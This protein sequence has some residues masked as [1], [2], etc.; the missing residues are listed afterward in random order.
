[1]SQPLR[2]ALFGG[3][4]DPVHCGHLRVARN[5]LEALNLDRIIFIPWRQSPHKEDGTLASE[6][7]RLEMLH[8]ALEDHPWAVVSEI[9]M[10]LPP[11]SYSWVTAEAMKEVYPEA[12][13][14]W[15]MGSDQWSVIQSWA[16]PDHPAALVELIVHHRAT[17]HPPP[18]ALRGPMRAAVGGAA[19]GL[20]GASAAGWEAGTAT[21]G[22]GAAWRFRR[23][24]LK[25]LPV[26]SYWLTHSCRSMGA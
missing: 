7:D 23:G 14:F 4:F 11:P 26:V 1:M 13:L 24:N 22:C 10:L 3:T 18:P 17:S 15:L 9:E 5:A 25:R 19:A 21:A 20:A 2:I 12:R 6:D 16:R 8:L